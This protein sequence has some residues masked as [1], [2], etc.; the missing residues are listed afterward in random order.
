M[1]K[2]IHEFMKVGLVQFMA[3]PSVMKGDGPIEETLKKIASDDYFDAVEVTWINDKRV[4][5]KARNIIETSHLTVAYGGQPRLL[6]AGLNVNHLNEDERLKAVASL[7]EGIDEA[8]E[9]GA[10]D[11]GF[12]S[13]KYSEERKEEAYQALV[14]ST[15]EL[16]KYAKS[17]GDLKVALEVFDYDVDK[18]SLI[19][20]A[21][22]AKRFAEEIRKEFDNFGLLVDLS[23]IPMI[24]ETIKE[25]LLP[26]QDYIIHAHMGNCVVKD[27]SLPGYGDSHPRFGFPGGEND[28]DELV[29]YL[30]VLK[31]IGFISKEKRPIVSFEVKPFG[32][33]DPD[34]VIANAKRVLN[35]AWAKL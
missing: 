27:P 13:G 2:S 6:T 24:H 32:D 23:H 15:R 17:R 10:C 18:K 30:G 22:L 16:C 3:Y 35:L 7:K 19:G 1:D 21:P 8:Y 5:E 14:K 4:R 12:L 29:E 9:I 26:V 28:V 25:S 11:F 33:E 20:P 31:S 34:L